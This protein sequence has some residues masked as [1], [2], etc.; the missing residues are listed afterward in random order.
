MASIGEAGIEL[1]FWPLLRGAIDVTQTRSI[2]LR[3]LL[4][5]GPKAQGN[6]ARAAV[7][8]PSKL[9]ALRNRCAARPPVVGGRIGAVLGASEPLAPYALDA[10][11]R[12]GH[13]ALRSWA[14]SSIL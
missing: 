8:S 4:E 10:V 1:R 14:G 13:T 2:G 6:S 11:A 3:L 5:G 7:W 12:Y 9:E